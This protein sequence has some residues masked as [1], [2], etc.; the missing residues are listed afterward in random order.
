MLVYTQAL[1]SRR[2]KYLRLDGTRCGCT[3]RRCDSSRA[4]TVSQ[5]VDKLFQY[6]AGFW[7]LNSRDE[8]PPDE[9]WPDDIGRWVPKEVI[10][11]AMGNITKKKKG[12][13]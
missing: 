1:F 12:S 11:I 5:M 13:V 9:L 4:P 7:I 2:S 3:I 8:L 10:M 6:A